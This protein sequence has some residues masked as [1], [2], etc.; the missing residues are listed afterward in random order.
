MTVYLSLLFIFLGLYSVYLFTSDALW[1]GLLLFFTGGLLG[2]TLNYF[3]FGFSSSF[4]QLLQHNKT[5]GMRAIIWMLGIAILLFAPL[6]WLQNWND[7][8]YY[9]FIRPLSV[10]IPLGAFLF[11]IGMQISCGCTSGTLN[12]V[13]QLQAL[14]LPTLFFMV[15]GGTL[16]AWSFSEWRDWPTWQPFAFQNH[17]GWSFGVAVQLLL[18]TSIYLWFKRGERRRHKA[19][20]PLLPSFHQPHPLLL[21]GI[22]LAL[23]NFL[24]L[25]LSGSPWSISSIFPYWGIRLIEL[26]SLP[27]DWPFWDYAMHNQQHLNAGLFSNQV[28]LTTMGV[29]AGAL[30]VSLA[31]PREKTP[32]N[33]KRVGA[34]ALG[35]LIMGFGAVMASGCNIG[36]FFSGI[37]SGS[38]HGWVWFLFALIGNYI[39]LKIRSRL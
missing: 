8:D 24:L 32:M 30:M 33:A 15:I 11:G 34:S 37:A 23:F 25:F 22:F 12:R 4:R 9:G 13:G 35:G 3:H 31:R 6:L 19:V 14:A 26:F 17:F 18:L 21:A 27:I 5:A 10:A 28:S 1:F 29:I 36:A 16:A 39:G 20:E 38:L 2:A 7:Q